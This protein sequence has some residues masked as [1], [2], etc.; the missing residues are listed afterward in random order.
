MFEFITS[1]A[2]TGL[3]LHEEP[4]LCTLRLIGP[5]ILFGGIRPSKGELW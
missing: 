3:A 2:A 1:I 5:S 4:F